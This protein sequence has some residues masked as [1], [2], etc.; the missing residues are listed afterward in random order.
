MRAVAI[1]ALVVLAA[2]TSFAN[3]IAIELYVDFDPPNGVVSVY[4]TPYTTV[5][6][7]VMADL[8]YGTGDG[9]YSVSFDV[10]VTDTM[11]P[12]TDF[13]PADPA[14]NV[15]GIVGDGITV[16]AE[17][18]I[19]SFPAR[20]GYVPIFYVGVPGLV[21]I[22]Q[23]PVQGHVFVT[24][25]ETGGEYTYCYVMDGGIGAEPGAPLDLCVNPVEDVTWGVIKSLYR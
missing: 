11:P 22:V 14:Y 16:V 8:G 23:H 3:P 6:A 5:Y 17:D 10:E 24:C 15:L 18:C 25:G 12:I 4:P 2:A 19:T 13:V 7:H 21:Q 1:V 20:L 9:V